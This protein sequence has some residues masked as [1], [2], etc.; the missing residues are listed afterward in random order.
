[1]TAAAG[2]LSRTGPDGS[3]MAERVEAAGCLRSVP[4][5]NAARGQADADAVMDAWMNSPGHRANILDRAFEEIGIGVHAG[6]GGP[7]GPRDFGGAR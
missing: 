3:T 6:D 1:M 4:G 7:W 2:V 5:E